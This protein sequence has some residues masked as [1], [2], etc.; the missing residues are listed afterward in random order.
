MNLIEWLKAT[1]DGFFLVRNIIWI[2]SGTFIILGLFSFKIKF[3]KIIKSLVLIGIGISFFYLTT[4][5]KNEEITNKYN[6]NIILFNSSNTNDLNLISKNVNQKYNEFNSKSI[7]NEKEVKEIIQKK[8]ISFSKEQIKLVA[9]GQA[10]EQ[11]KIPMLFP[12]SCEK[13]NLC[14]GKKTADKIFPKLGI[15]RRFDIFGIFE[16]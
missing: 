12:Y 8:H 6:E 4:L 13:E 11:M 3:L 9:K 7:A 1:L 5:M 16:N 15:E 10:V 2:I 14:F